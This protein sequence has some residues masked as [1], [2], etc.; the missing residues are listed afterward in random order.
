MA[1]R[2]HIRHVSGVCPRVRH[3]DTPHGCCIRVSEVREG[4]QKVGYSG[5]VGGLK[6][7]VQ[8]LWGVVWHNRM[9][10]AVAQQQILMKG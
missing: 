1:Y 5:A 9:N 4:S 6:M 2:T 3:T 7:L 8:A 10:L